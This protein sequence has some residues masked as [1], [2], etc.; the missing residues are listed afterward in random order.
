MRPEGAYMSEWT[1]SLVQVIAYGP[2]GA[3]PLPEINADL[4]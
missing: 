1:M 2:F 4:F 3:E